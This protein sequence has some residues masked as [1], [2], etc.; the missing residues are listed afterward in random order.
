MCCAQALKGVNKV[1]Y[2]TE[3]SQLMQPCMGLE[4]NSMGAA[5]G[6]LVA[7]RGAATAVANNIQ[8]LLGFR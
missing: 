8:G 4:E 2:T 6:P 3:Q 7:V 5:L 1:I